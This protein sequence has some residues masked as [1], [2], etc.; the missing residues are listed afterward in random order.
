MLLKIYIIRI[1]LPREIWQLLLF[2]ERLSIY[3]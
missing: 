1:R 2:L 3:H